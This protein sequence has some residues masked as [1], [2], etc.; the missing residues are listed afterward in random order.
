MTVV[1]VVQII[2]L[3][4]YNMCFDKATNLTIGV[5]EACILEYFKLG[6]TLDNVINCFIDSKRV[7]IKDTLRSCNEELSILPETKLDYEWFVI[8]C[9][10]YVLLIHLSLCIV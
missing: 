4:C 1:E 3:C 9:M 7:Y 10:F 2:K 8:V 6:G 5:Y